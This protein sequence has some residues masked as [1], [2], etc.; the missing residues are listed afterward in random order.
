[1]LPGGAGSE[2]LQEPRGAGIYLL[3]AFFL[4]PSSSG[5]CAHELLSCPPGACLACS[6]T[7]PVIPRLPR[8][9][10]LLQPASERRGFQLGA[11]SQPSCRIA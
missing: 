8:W 6:R 1:M 4:P 2:P 7:V 3:A 9:R 10:G 11:E 5:G